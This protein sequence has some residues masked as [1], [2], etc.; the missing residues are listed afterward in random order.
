MINLLLGVGTMTLCL[1]LQALL[2]AYVGKYYIGHSGRLGHA[3]FARV[4]ALVCGVMLMLILGNLAQV[5]IW[6]ALFV[7][8]G[9]F[10]G[11]ADAFYHSAVNFATL[12]YG[13][14]VMSNAH[15]L[16]GP[17]EAIS[18]V[19]MIGVSTAILIAVLQD[20][21]RRRHDQSP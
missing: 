20:V 5:G 9:E 8:L 11:L 12:G 17:L 16:L 14:V 21:T 15:R 1:I 6:A 10:D 3:R 7:W 13:D 4:L 19:L 18:G 2:L